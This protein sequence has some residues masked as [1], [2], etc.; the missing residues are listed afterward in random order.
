[1]GA[2]RA[3]FLGGIG[4]AVSAAALMVVTDVALPPLVTLLIVGI[5]LIATSR[6]R[7]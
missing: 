6:R 7:A 2:D 4:L 5:A 1:M 3:R